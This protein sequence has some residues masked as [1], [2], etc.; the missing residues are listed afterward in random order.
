[1]EVDFSVG[2][3]VRTW[4]PDAV[5]SLVVIIIFVV[6]LAAWKAGVSIPDC[7]TLAAAAGCGVGTPAALPRKAK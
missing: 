6:S 3:A 1:V 7:I 5:R 4:A 2:I